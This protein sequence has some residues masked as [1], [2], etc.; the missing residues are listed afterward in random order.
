MGGFVSHFT[1]ND[2]TQKS[3][4]AAYWHATGI[5]M[6]MVYINFTFHQFRTF[7]SLLACK[8][9]VA[10]GGLIYQK[11]LQIL[12]ASVEDGQNGQMISLLSNDLTKFDFRFGFFTFLFEIPIE[13]FAY[14]VMCY[15]EIGVSAVIGMV[16]L[17]AFTPLQSKYFFE[18]V[19]LF[20]LC[21]F[22]TI[23]NVDDYVCMKKNDV[24]L[25][26]STLNVTFYFMRSNFRNSDQGQFDS[27]TFLSSYA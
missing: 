19:I 5:V 23:R 16:F 10:C 21:K 3:T 15:M 2:S 25:G 1:N 6:S 8:I 12:K 20:G 11:S 17:L 14:F 18:S 26:K 13:F 24:V 7:K 27:F 9:R 4:A 22:A